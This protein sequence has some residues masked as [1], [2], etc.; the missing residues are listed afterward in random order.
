[1]PAEARLLPPKSPIAL[2]ENR[3]I[4]LVRVSAGASS[5]HKVVE[6]Q[7]E[8]DLQSRHLDPKESPPFPAT[9]PPPVYRHNVSSIAAVPFDLMDMR[10]EQACKLTVHAVLR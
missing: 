7:K 4:N 9:P 1:M 6:S 5:V 3:T 10:R 8:H 2:D